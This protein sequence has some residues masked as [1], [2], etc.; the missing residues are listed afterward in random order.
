MENDEAPDRVRPDM[1]GD[2]NG[3]WPALGQQREQGTT[4]GLDLPR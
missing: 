1:A 4:S 3:S 2:S